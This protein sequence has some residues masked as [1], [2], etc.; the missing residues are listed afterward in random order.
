LATWGAP[1]VRACFALPGGLP[2]PAAADRYLVF[3]TLAGAWPIEPERLD[4]YLEKA[5]REAKRT[6]SW[7]DPEQ[8]HEAALKAYARGLIELPEFRA[9]FDPFVA[10]LAAAGERAALG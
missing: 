5:L 6:T 7:G 4:G 1:H 9:D 2:G 3:Q 8:A 10:E